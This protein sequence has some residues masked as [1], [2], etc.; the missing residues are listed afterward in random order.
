[1]PT[2][3][4]YSHRTDNPPWSLVTEPNLYLSTTFDS[5]TIIWQNQACFFADA[6]VAMTDG[7][8]PV[9][10]QQAW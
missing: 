9:S 5:F 4:V 3:S 1:M 2:Y 7:R 10:L 8:V 6:C